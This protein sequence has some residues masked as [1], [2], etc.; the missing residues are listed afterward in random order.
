MYNN[1]V[2]KNIKFR[3]KLYMKKIFR[4]TRNII[5]YVSC[6]ANIFCKKIPPEVFYGLG[7]E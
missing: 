2:Q 5:F 1:T 4:F 7:G 6:G 3:V